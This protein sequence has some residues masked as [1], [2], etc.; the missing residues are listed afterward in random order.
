MALAR[1]RKCDLFALAC[2]FNLNPSD[3]MKVI[4]LQKLITESEDYTEELAKN[5]LA[6]IVE[7]RIEGEKEKAKQEE[8]RKEEER[9]KREEEK[10]RIT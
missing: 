3:D 8:E 7:E 1:S 10:L 6:V 5:M 2:E 4:Q 9:I